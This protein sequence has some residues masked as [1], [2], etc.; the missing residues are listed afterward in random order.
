MPRRNSDCTA[1]RLCY[2]RGMEGLTGCPS[3]KKKRAEYMRR[4]NRANA[5]RINAQRRARHHRHT[6]GLTDAEKSELF[7]SS[8][9]LCAVCLEE[10]ATHIDHDHKTGEVRGALCAR[11]NKGLG[12]IESMDLSAVQEYLETTWKSAA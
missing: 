8:D 2:S 3:C 6:Y 1:E 9:G 4:Y 12:Y 5:D 10:P 7:R 11:C